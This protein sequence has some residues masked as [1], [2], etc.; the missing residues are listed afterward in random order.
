[1][2]QGLWRCTH[3]HTHTHTHVHVNTHMAQAATC[4]HTHTHTHRHT[5]ALCAHSHTMTSLPN[6][7]PFPS[8][9]PSVPCVSPW[10]RSCP[11]SKETSACCKLQ[12][13]TPFPGLKVL[14]NLV[15]PSDHISH[16][17]PPAHY[18]LFLQQKY[19]ALT[20]TSS[21]FTYCFLSPKYFSPRS[22]TGCPLPFCLS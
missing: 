12:I 20:H 13:K 4:T 16:L 19:T 1:M 18:S 21:P 3:T 7:P 17:H 22:S 2:I 10:P 6:Q 14:G 5:P 8:I 9:H 15:Y 11:R